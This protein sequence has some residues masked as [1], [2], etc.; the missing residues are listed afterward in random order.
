MKDKETI[1]TTSNTLDKEFYNIPLFGEVKIEHGKDFKGDYS[2]GEIITNSQKRNAKNLNLRA[3]DD[4]LSGIGIYKND[5]LTFELNAQLRNG[6]IAV[7]QLGYKIYVRKI[8]FDKKRIRLESD[9]NTPSP[10]I[11]DFD[12]PGFEMLGKVT[13]V[14]R[15]L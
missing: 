15:E 1:I 7:I 5:F 2:L 8:Y 11:I 9:S 12:T 3:T 6:D 14:T 13:T 4:G 10:L